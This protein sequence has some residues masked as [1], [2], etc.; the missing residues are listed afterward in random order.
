MTIRIRLYKSQEDYG[1]RGP[2]MLGN[3]AALPEDPIGTVYQAL[4]ADRRPNKVDLGIGVY[5][6]AA[7]KSPVMGAVREAQARVVAQQ[8][9]KAYL[10]PRGNADYLALMERLVLGADHVVLKDG[11]IFSTQ[12][13]GAGGGLRCA[14]E[15]IKRASPGARIWVPR[16]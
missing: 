9:S 2:R 13:P 16:P 6:D 5:R 4:A 1:D 3:L 10:P 8:E 11:R 7:G 15:F 12:T 14:A